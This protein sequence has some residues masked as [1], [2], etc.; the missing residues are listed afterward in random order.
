LSSKAQNGYPKNNFLAQV[1]ESK[2]IEEKPFS[3]KSISGKPENLDIT[4]I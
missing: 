3:I 2:F 4:I 1:H